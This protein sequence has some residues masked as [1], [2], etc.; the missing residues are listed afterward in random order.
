MQDD[1][2]GRYELVSRLGA[3]GFGVVHKA[4]QLST[5]QWV[6]IKLHSNDAVD[7]RLRETRHARFAQEAK[8]CAE[9]RH[10][11]I[12]PLVDFGRTKEG[13]LFTAFSWTPGSDLGQVLRESGPPSAMELARWM[14]QLLD[15]LAAAHAGGVVHRDL[16]PSNVLVTSQGA[17]RNVVLLDFGIARVMGDTLRVTQT[18]DTLGTPGYG[19]P[20][21]WRGQES[22]P[23]SDLFAWGLIFL[24]CVTGDP[25]YAGATGDALYQLL[26]AEEVP[27]PRRVLSHPVASLLRRVLAKDPAKRD[28]SAAE[29]HDRLQTMSLDDLV[30]PSSAAAEGSASTSP[31]G[32]ELAHRPVS[33]LSVLLDVGAAG[34]AALDAALAGPIQTVRAII[35]RHGGHLVSVAGRRMLAYWGFPFA[36]EGDAMRAV[37][38][39]LA[40]S[41]SVS[42]LATKARVALHHGAVRAGGAHAGASAVAVIAEQLCESSTGGVVASDA[43]TRL[44]RDTIESEPFAVGSTRILGEKRRGATDLRPKVPSVGRETELRLLVERW[45][46]AASGAG[47]CVLLTGEPGI[48]KSRAAQELFDRVARDGRNAYLELRC[49]PE[50]RHTVL[51]PVIEALGADLDDARSTSLD[52]VARSASVLAR[53]TDAGLDAAEHGPIVLSFLGLPLRGP[54]G[55]LASP[56]LS[57]QKIRERALT[58]LTQL[59]VA[60]AERV[61]LLLLAEDLHWADETTLDLIGRLIAEV[62]SAS[63]LL[64]MTAR[65]EFAPPFPTMNMLQLQLTRLQ[66]A[67]VADIVSSL[68][69]D[70]PVVPDLVDQVMDRTDG[71]PLFVEEL[72]RDLL[73]GPAAGAGTIPGTL[74]ALLTA[75]LDKLDDAKHTAQLASVLG[76]EFREEWLHAVSER[77]QAMT[78]EHV[79]RLGRAGLMMRRRRGRERTLV[80]NHA[81]MR[82]A[83]YASISDATRE[84]MHARVADTLESRFSDVTE[85]RPDLLATHLA[86]G[87]QR[88]RA[89]EYATKAAKRALDRSAYAE[90]IAQAARAIDWV[91]HVDANRRVAAELEANGLL[92]QA[93]MSFKGWAD[94][95]VKRRVDRSADLLR[96]LDASS[97]QRVPNLWALITYHHV[98]ANRR[99]A[100]EA[101]YEALALAEASGDPGLRAAAHTMLAITLFS[102]GEIAAPLAAVDQAIA[103]YDRD[104]HRNHGLLFGLDSLVLATAVRA[105]CLWHTEREDEARLTTR[106]ALAWARET[107]HAPSLAIGLLYCCQIH[108]M[109]G[110]KRMTAEMTGEIL[111]LSAQYG[112]P[113]FEGYAVMVH[114]WAIGDEGATEHILPVMAHLGCRTFL[115]YYAH[116]RADALAATDPARALAIIDECLAHADTT[117]EH[118]FTAELLLKKASLMTDPARRMAV[119]TEAAEMGKRRGH[120]RTE[121]LARAALRDSQA[122]A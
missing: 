90:T 3:G 64:V 26:G 56:D 43:F 23:A 66:R 22:T 89:V 15:A 44:V 42:E 38:A 59:F 24:E 27:I 52:R 77:S 4:K 117:S 91:P 76:R 96:A 95:E 39:A 102:E 73:E 40:V 67:D 53:L 97:E 121:A 19:A 7:E 33:A 55:D 112:L 84:R 9:I 85:S 72:A 13:G 113:A 92:T 94:A 30:S 118:F 20:E 111:G 47:Q 115:S 100:R 12:V 51:A 83:A 105:H 103:L 116:L 110:N 5:G 2:T 122:L 101:A 58:S 80:F 41:A 88:P 65:P 87:N 36:E 8:I 63:V 46:R 45:G 29:I 71:V 11:N 25:V 114:G 6:A 78:E 32:H 69:G 57:P 108:Q 18:G 1:L 50:S 82:D 21:Q 81:L 99:E 10:P 79:D 14:L 98:A 31:A 109:D 119:L 75:R 28:S 86:E 70:K 48:G 61:P 16:K 62:P 93:M 17:R 49:A 54:S 106:D 104:K 35:A 34:E 60:S 74:Q 120:Q 37:R 68:A 107:G